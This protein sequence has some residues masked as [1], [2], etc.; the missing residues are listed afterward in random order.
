MTV[1]AVEILNC[2]NN[3]TSEPNLITVALFLREL[4]ALDCDIN[5]SK[6]QNITLTHF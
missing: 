2:Y 4:C 1:V 3:K 6:R 5:I